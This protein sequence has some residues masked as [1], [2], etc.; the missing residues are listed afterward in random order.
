[1]PVRAYWRTAPFA[2]LGELY[3]AR[4][5]RNVSQ[6]MVSVF[7]S[8]FLY[9]NG[10][11]LVEIMLLLAGYYFLRTIISFFLPFYIAWV[12]PKRAT[13]ASNIFAVPSLIALTMIEEYTLFAVLGYF[14]FQAIS[15][16]L[17]AIASDMHFSS[18]KNDNRE[19]KEIG[20][21]HIVEKFGTGIAPMVG[22]FIAY[23][24]GP[25]NTMWMAAILSIASA[26]PLFITP[27]LIP[28]KQKVI[29]HGLPWKKIRL[30]LFSAGA[31]GADMLVSGATWSIFVAIAVFGTESDSV[32]AKLGIVLSISLVVSLIVTRLYGVLIDRRRGRELFQTGVVINSF[33][34]ASRSLIGTPIGV[35][36]LNSANEVG[37]SAYQMPY[38]R[39]EFDMAD[40]LPGYRIVYIA[41]MRIA[42]CI[43]ATLL[44]LLT[45]WLIWQF[46]EVLGMQI[47]FM[48]MS[49]VTFL[50]LC[51]GFP[52]LRTDN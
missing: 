46:G 8:I 23:I 16:S 52:T 27:E 42:A 25:E 29:Y 24:F 48:V 33:V 35:V 3:A 36:M 15:I 41:I 45:A 47:S 10:Y 22:G 30:Q 14:I 39:S 26:V 19:G 44:A 31:S 51:N 7:V 1:M 21:L 17:F 43:G 6:S 40:N 11:S 4:F 13:L 12:G 50:L 18:I 34:H 38:I 37:T 5:L 9:Q 32:Y 2:E 49:G 20:W 28:R